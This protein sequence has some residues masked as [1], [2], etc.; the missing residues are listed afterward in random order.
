ML[1]Q[2]MEI[3]SGGKLGAGWRVAPRRGHAI[4]PMGRLSLTRFTVLRSR[5]GLT[6]I[7]CGACSGAISAAVKSHRML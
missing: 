2:L 5:R 7:A 6:R 3:L 1:G 4:C